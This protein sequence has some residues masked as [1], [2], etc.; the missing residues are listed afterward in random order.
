M[1][2]SL[3]A[4]SDD[5]LRGSIKKIY[6]KYG[7]DGIKTIHYGGYDGDGEPWYDCDYQEIS[8][9]RIAMEKE[10]VRREEAA[11]QF[12]NNCPELSS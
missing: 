12:Y 7:E 11:N 10:L 5:H 8:P 6:R 3:S 2:D 9:I 4:M 1:E